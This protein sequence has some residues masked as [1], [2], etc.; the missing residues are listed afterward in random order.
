M[1]HECMPSE[2]WHGAKA[3]YYF[4]RAVDKELKETRPGCEVG[5][6]EKGPFFQHPRTYYLF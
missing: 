1:N 5:K 6:Y 3:L 2:V 4:A